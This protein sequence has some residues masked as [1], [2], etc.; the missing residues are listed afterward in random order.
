MFGGG[1]ISNKMISQSHS[2]Q[3]RLKPLLAAAPQEIMVHEIYASIQGESTWA[4]V[5]CTFIRTT[6]CHLRCSYCD[7][8]HAF[9][10]GKPLSVAA[11]LEEVA[12][13]DLAMVEIT[14]GEPL[15]QLSV[16]PL[17]QALCDR[18]YRVLLETSGSLDIRSVDPRV[19]RIVDFKAPSSRE[20]G[21]N[22]YSNI[23][24]LTARDEVKLVLGDADDYAWATELISSNGLHERCSV[25]LSTVFGK[26]SPRHL[27][28]WIV[29]DRL[30]V[31][32]QLQMHK[33]IWE[34]DARGV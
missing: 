24:A 4:G 10:H 34:P 15:L 16:L 28:E 30:P 5:P 14:G 18:G 22:L 1:R 12:Q 8:P 20:V 32:L 33:Y 19:H 29:R 2:A 11:I 6:A 26:L 21:A 25:L 27:A 17:M 23:A 9:T 7:T 3:K 31:R 13:C